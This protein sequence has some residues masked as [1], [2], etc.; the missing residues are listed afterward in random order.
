MS[1]MRWR[2]VAA[3]VA[4]MLGAACGRAELRSGEPRSGAN[5]TR[6]A[7]ATSDDCQPCHRAITQ[8]WRGSGHARAWLDPLVAR[9]YAADPDPSCVACHAPRSLGAGDGPDPSARAAQDGVDCVSCH[10]EGETLVR[11]V[12]QST[13]ASASGRE[14]LARAET[15]QT[16]AACHQFR[17]LPIDPSEGLAYDPTAW[18][19]DTY[20]EWSRSRAA[21]AQVGCSDCHMPVVDQAGAPHRSHAFVGMQDPTL[22][23][24]A[25]RVAVVARREGG[26]VFVE[27][28]LR[29]GAIGHAFPTGDLFRQGVL[30]VW[31]Q[32]RESAAGEFLL[33]R[34]FASGASGYMVEVEDTRVPPPGAGELPPIVFRLR[35]PAAQRVGWSLDLRATTSDPPRPDDPRTRVA[36]GDVAIE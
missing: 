30:R 9:E 14:A 23:G 11:A 21:A 29:P 1:V 10:V 31:T 36:A 3:S 33:E 20:G 35:S 8:E 4:L 2:G 25:V 19:Q 26:S 18:L 13:K 15:S 28:T 24:A 32:E 12:N 34:R 16:C 17:F 22:V 6:L 27:V 7:T 5:H